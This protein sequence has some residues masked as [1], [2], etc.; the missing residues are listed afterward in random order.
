M[1]Q[2]VGLI[3]IMTAINAVRRRPGGQADL[4]RRSGCSP[5]YINMVVNGEGDP[6]EPVLR[7]LGFRKLVSISYERVT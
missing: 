5:A 3:D 4:A 1:S 7:A 2:A 6:S